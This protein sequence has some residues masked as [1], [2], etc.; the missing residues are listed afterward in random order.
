MKLYE[1]DEKIE[2]VLMALEPDPET[3]EVADDGEI[4]ARLYALEGE[5]KHKLENCAKMYFEARAEADAA[6][7]EKQRFADR[8]ASADKRAERMLRF[9]A[10][11]TG[12]EETDCG[13][14]TLKFPKPRPSL[15]TTDV[16]AATDW[17]LKN[18]YFDLYTYPEAKLCANE[19]KAL[20]LDGAE[21][22]G[23]ELEYTK[24]AVL[25]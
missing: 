19:V 1:I 3:G 12:G 21:I 22:P 16:S 5:R 13:I 20:L 11:V 9:L 10:Y 14:A 15:K 25:K 2:Q 8:Q 18:G 7:A 17:L 23:V 4:M 24:K 6:K